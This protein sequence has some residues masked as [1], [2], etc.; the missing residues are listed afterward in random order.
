M[1]PGR[2]VTR[3]MAGWGVVRPVMVGRVLARI[4]LARIVLARMVMAG[5]GAAGMVA[6]GHDMAAGCVVSF[7]FY[8]KLLG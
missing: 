1:L 2:P 4:V 5:N 3:R 7:L 6:F 8:R